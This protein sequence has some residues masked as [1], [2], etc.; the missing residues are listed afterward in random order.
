MIQKCYKV[1]YCILY[2]IKLFGIIQS[3]KATLSN[4]REGIR[5]ENGGK[6]LIMN[7]QPM[8]YLNVRN[9][10]SGILCKL[11]QEQAMNTL[12]LLAEKSQIFIS[13][14]VWTQILLWL[15]SYIIFLYYS[16][17]QC[18]SDSDENVFHDF[19]VVLFSAQV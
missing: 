13:I 9:K 16:I 11:A 4:T 18:W 19:S 17:F 6:T 2:C 15:S 14:I 7:W 1:L 3:M 8:R 10:N 5:E 12:N